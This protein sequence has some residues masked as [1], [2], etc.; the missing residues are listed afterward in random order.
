MAKITPRIQ[1]IAQRSAGIRGAIGASR[2]K[3]QERINIEGRLAEERRAIADT[4]S[5]V[6][7]LAKTGIETKQD[8]ELYKRGGGEEGIYGFLTKPSESA[9][10]IEKGREA[11]EQLSRGDFKI[12]PPSVKDIQEVENLL[13]S[14][15]EGTEGMTLEELTGFKEVPDTMISQTGLFPEYSIESQKRFNQMGI[16]IEGVDRAGILERLMNRSTSA[17]SNMFDRMREE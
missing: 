8:F 10:F 5:Q 13:Q 2:A 15:A 7:N 3:V 4:I 6:G 12:A 16:D 1:R 17:F 11:K 14:G 9:A